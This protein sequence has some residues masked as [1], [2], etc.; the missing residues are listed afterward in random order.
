MKAMVRYLLPDCAARPDR[1]SPFHASKYGAKTCAGSGV[2]AWAVPAP[3]RARPA[4]ATA[5]T[6]PVRR[7]RIGLR[8]GPVMDRAPFD[9]G[10][11][12]LPEARCWSG[13]ILL[14]W[15]TQLSRV[16]TDKA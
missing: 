4:D 1:L 13:P 3:V 11:L 15:T 10:G 9:G 2:A 6:R 14:V 12:Q 7:A 8:T 5:V 16:L